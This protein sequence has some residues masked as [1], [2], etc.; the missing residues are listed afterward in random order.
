[1]GVYR[2]HPNSVMVPPGAFFIPGGWLPH[3][4]RTRITTY[5]TFDRRTDKLPDGRVVRY[6]VVR[7]GPHAGRTFI[8]ILL[9]GRPAK[10][11]NKPGTG[12]VRV[13]R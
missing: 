10:L 1:M 2:P 9:G 7:T 12:L 5:K 8:S 13:V 4:V 11:E 6:D 3:P